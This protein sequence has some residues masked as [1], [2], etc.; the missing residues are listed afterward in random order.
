MAGM[1]KSV[2]DAKRAST[3]NR[4]KENREEGVDVGS[5]DRGHVDELNAQVQRQ[6]K[7]ILSLRAELQASVTRIHE[8]SSCSQRIEAVKEPR[9]VKLKVRW[10]AKV[11]MRY[12]VRREPLT[13]SIL[14]FFRKGII[15][16][17]EERGAAHRTRDGTRNS[18]CAAGLTCPAPRDIPC[19]CAV[20]P[21]PAC[22]RALRTALT[23]CGRKGGRDT[24]PKSR[25]G[26]RV[27]AVE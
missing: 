2:Q 21:A 19:E 3:K 26:P 1:S 9:G 15:E 27:A 4:E 25:P 17:E 5:G 24:R 16:T 14:F 10:G 22:W 6:H 20:A 18:G 23:T 8:Q 12:L 7:I 11:A 13:H